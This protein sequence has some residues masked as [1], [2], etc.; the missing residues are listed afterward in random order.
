[1]G[2]F[3]YETACGTV[4]GH[5]SNI[6]GYTQFVATTQDGRRSTTVSIDSQLS[7]V[8]NPTR[9]D[10]LR[11]IFSAIGVRSVGMSSPTQV[12]GDSLPT[13]GKSE[14]RAGTGSQPL[15]PD[16]FKRK[17]QARSEPM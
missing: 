1:M 13:C 4:Y 9:F 6:L 16:P 15:C 12:S 17:H 14:Y 2:I 3:R 10:E 8:M 11:N 7:A 5:T